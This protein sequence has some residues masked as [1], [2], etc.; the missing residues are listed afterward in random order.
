MGLDYGWGPTAM[1]ETLL[2]LV[3]INTGSAWWAS[4][5][6]SLVIIRLA[7]L[8]FYFM[9]ADVNARN[10]LIAPYMNPLSARMKAAQWN[11]DPAGMSKVLAEMRVLRASAGVAYWKM[12]MPFIQIPIGFGMFRL[13]R[14]MSYLPVPGFDTGGALWLQDLT[15]SDPYLILPVLTGACYFYT[16]KVRKIPYDFD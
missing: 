9:S 3:H 1:I 7:T 5:G 2:E 11:R 15:L 4:I 14:G 6:I 13:M 10:Q 8:K 12:F 16:F